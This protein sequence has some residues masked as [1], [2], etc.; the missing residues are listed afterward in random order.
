MK[1][2]ENGLNPQQLFPFDYRVREA[3]PVICIHFLMIQKLYHI[4]R[5]KKRDFFIFSKTG[6][7]QLKMM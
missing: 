7:F 5:N 3:V 4:L 6:F 1:Y 2:G